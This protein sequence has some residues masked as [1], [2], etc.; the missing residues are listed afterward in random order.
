MPTALAGTDHK[1]LRAGRLGWVAVSA[2][3]VF[4]TA[5]ALWPKPVGVDGGSV[6][7]GPMSVSVEEEGKTRIK[8]VYVVSAPQSGIVL[9][10]P[11]L[12]GD[13]VTKDK[14]LVAELQPAHPPF[15]DVRT[16]LELIANIKAAEAAVRLAEA[17]LERAHAD[18]RFADAEII[19]ARALAKSK[20]VS[21]QVL[22]K[23]E[24]AVFVAKAAVER[25]N[26]NVT[27]QRRQLESVQ[28]KLADP[29]DEMLDGLAQASCCVEVRAPVTGRVLKVHQTSEQVVPAGTSL[30]EIGDPQQIEIVVELLSTDAVKIAEGALA[31]IIGW[32]GS[33]TLTGKV[34]RIETAGFTKV[35]A[36]GIEEQRVR[37]IIDLDEESRTRHTLGHEFRVLARIR[38]WSSESVL[39]IPIGA[40]FR[41]QGKW[42]TYRITNDRAVLAAVELGHRNETEAE[43]ISGL[44][45]G[46]RIILYP[47][48]RVTNGV[49]VSVRRVEGR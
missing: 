11:L 14:T 9:R 31:E 8:D 46:D 42:A 7:K 2:L 3:V 36:L 35:S 22:E 10:S 12:A 27:V 30:A 49:R 5:W 38:V 37:V 6:T 13:A 39:R 24:H 29:R 18:R 4:A 40:L 47:S 34:R 32:G 16:R 1:W 43:V 20:T 41:N 45:E 23:A 15:I 17:E 25:A 48:D 26:A 28:A 44:S 33:D 19:R 21:E